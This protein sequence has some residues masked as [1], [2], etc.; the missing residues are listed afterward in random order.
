M[1]PASGAKSEIA[2][3]DNRSHCR[4]T[5]YSIPVSRRTPCA[6]K[7]H[8]RVAISPRVIGSPVVFPSAPSTALRR[9]ASGI[10]TGV[11]ESFVA[12]ASAFPATAMLAKAASSARTNRGLQWANLAIAHSPLRLGR[13]LAMRWRFRFSVKTASAGPRAPRSLENLVTPSGRPPPV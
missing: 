8:D 1:R 12:V 5:A 7:Y 13:R 9:A 11:S 3:L 6:P 4:L 10:V 2:P